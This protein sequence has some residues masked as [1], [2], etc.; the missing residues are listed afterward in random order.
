MARTTK[1]ERKRRREAALVKISEGYDFAATSETPLLALEI[2][3]CCHLIA[4]VECERFFVADPRHQSFTA[5]LR[6]PIPGKK[7]PPPRAGVW[8]LLIKP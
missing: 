6:M 3:R 4:Q 5:P 7:K 2:N 8:D 1:A